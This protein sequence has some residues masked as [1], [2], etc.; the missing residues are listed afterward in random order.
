[1]LREATH[2]FR[3]RQK[4]ALQHVID[5]LAIAPDLAPDLVAPP[6]EIILDFGFGVVRGLKGL[7]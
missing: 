7:S 6:N 2:A 4:T 3:R 5:G 1:L